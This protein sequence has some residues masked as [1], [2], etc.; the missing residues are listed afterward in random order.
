MSSGISSGGWGLPRGRTELVV[1]FIRTDGIIVLGTRVI[2]QGLRAARLINS[3]GS[4]DQWARLARPRPAD[5]ST[6]RYKLVA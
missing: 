3:Q 2:E 1:R 4:T 6:F 5:A